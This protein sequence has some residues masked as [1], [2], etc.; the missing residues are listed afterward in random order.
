MHLK[1]LTKSSNNICL[2]FNELA[3]MVSE[4][5]NMKNMLIS[6]S[7]YKIR[8]D[9]VIH[10]GKESS[11]DM[12]KWDNAGDIASMSN[13]LSLISSSSPAIV[14]VVLNIGT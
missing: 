9:A 3:I 14:S 11:N 2:Q 13:S 4:K 8:I 1:I 6:L 7:Y 12:Y 5:F 10:D